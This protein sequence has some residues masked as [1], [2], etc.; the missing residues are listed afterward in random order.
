MD[1]ECKLK[2]SK[3]SIYSENNLLVQQRYTFVVRKTKL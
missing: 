1:S 2:L 3:Y